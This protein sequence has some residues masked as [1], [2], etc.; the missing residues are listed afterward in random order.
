VNITFDSCYRL[1][2]ISEGANFDEYD[3]KGSFIQYFAALSRFSITSHYYSGMFKLLLEMGAGFL[4][5]SEVLISFIGSHD[6]RDRCEEQYC[7]LQQLLKLGATANIP[8]Y[9]F[10]PLQIAVYYFDLVGVEYLLE[11]GANPHDV[12]DPDGIAYLW[13]SGSL[14][15]DLNEDLENVC[16][17]S[18][19]LYHNRNFSDSEDEKRNFDGI[20]A[21][22]TQYSGTCPHH[23]CQLE[24]FSDEDE[25]DGSVNMDD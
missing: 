5:P 19:L 21:I 18:V 12:G 4:D 9:R 6:H 13:E 22:L 16:P 20:R 17:L 14:L 1:P 7:G 24:E 10:T 8:G 23:T 25:D 2:W 11:A 15:G 3:F